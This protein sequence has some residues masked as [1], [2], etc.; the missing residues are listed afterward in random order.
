M[1]SEEEDCSR[2]G[3]VGVNRIIPESTIMDTDFSQNETIFDTT[4]SSG[5]MGGIRFQKEDD[6]INSV[7]D[8]DTI[9]FHTNDDNFGGQQIIP[10]SNITET[11]FTVED[12]NFDTIDGISLVDSIDRSIS[13]G[14]ADVDD[15]MAI[16]NKLGAVIVSIGNPFILG[17]MGP[18]DEL[19]I[20]FVD[21][22]RLPRVVS[23]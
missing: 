15:G 17:N 19:S 13:V 4:C 5:P 12:E 9:P 11:D 3:N 8:H 23:T 22:D 6:I 14:I 16:T 10:C 1:K 7:H 20:I 18:G 2:L 21:E